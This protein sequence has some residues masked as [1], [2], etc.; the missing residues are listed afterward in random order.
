MIELTL[1]QVA[2]AVR[3]TL[4]LAGT[5]LSFGVPGIR[6]DVETTSILNQG[7]HGLREVL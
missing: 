3:G 5:A 1:Q 4:V 2:D 6:D 7:V